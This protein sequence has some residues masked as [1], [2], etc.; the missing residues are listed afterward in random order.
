MYDTRLGRRWQLDPKPSFTFSSYCVFLNCPILYND[1]LGDT[2]KLYNYQ[3]Q[4]TTKQSSEFNADPMDILNVIDQSLNLEK[5]QQRAFYVDEK[6]TLQYDCSK[7]E[8]YSQEQMK[9]ADELMNAI[10]DNSIIILKTANGN[11][12]LPEIPGNLDNSGGGTTISNGLSEDGIRTIY[13]VKNEDDIIVNRDPSRYIYGPDSENPLKFT[14]GIILL[15]EIG[16]F[17]YRKILAR[18]THNYFVIQVEDA[19]RC[20]LNY[21]T[22]QTHDRNFWKNYW[23]K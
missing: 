14:R 20:R 23:K 17:N 7:M 13:I 12:D 3:G 15:H 2:V 1:P 10:D 16:H 4:T 18:E 9:I 21:E 22:R 11:S 6:N 5:N 19:V 8:S